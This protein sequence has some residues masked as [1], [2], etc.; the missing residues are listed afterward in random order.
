V[1]G[2]SPPGV[3]VP[4]LGRGAGV[5]G[6]QPLGA[7]RARRSALP[8]A[9]THV[10]HQVRDHL[11]TPTPDDEPELTATTALAIGQEL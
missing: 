8:E 7:G 5:V 9:T 3:R 10:L 2:V 4:F 6:A 11:A 1:P